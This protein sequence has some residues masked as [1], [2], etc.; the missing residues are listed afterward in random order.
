VRPPVLLTHGDA[1]D[2][3]PIQAMFSAANGLGAVGVAVSWH[4]SRGV[5]HGIGPDSLDLAGR[6][7]VDAF[8]GRLAGKP[9]N[10]PCA[11]PELAATS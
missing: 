5:G 4:V 7:L 3:I 1:D 9:E 8:A 2:M 10:A 6:F 11:W